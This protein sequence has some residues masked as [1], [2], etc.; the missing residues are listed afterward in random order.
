MAT[1]RTPH[2]L[3]L[4]CLL[5]T[6]CTI[7]IVQREVIVQAPTKITPDSTIEATRAA[8]PERAD[9]S[10]DAYTAADMQI[11]P[12]LQDHSVGG[13]PYI[14]DIAI[15][16]DGVWVGSQYGVS[17]FDGDSWITY[18]HFDGNWVNYASDES[19]PT[20]HVVSSVRAVAVTPDGTVWVGGEM[21]IASFDG[22]RWTTHSDSTLLDTGGCHIAV[23]SIAVGQDGKLWASTYLGLICFDGRTWTSYPVPIYSTPDGP[24]PP[25]VSDIAVAHDGSVWGAAWPDAYHFDG[26]TWTFYVVAGD[27][28]L[29]RT[30]DAIT[31][32]D[33][34]LEGTIDANAVAIADDG[35]VWFGG[36]MGI[37]SFDGTSWTSYDLPSGLHDVADIALAPEGTLWFGGHNG[38]SHSDGYNW[39]TYT[40]AD[41][42]IYHIVRSIAIADDGTVWI[43]TESGLSCYRPLP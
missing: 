10:W 3:L 8:Q 43:G 42:L 32:I 1:K 12:A 38:I 16:P 37:A 28:R 41:G 36:G 17:H 23:R 34:G 7:G 14:Y 26:S 24:S 15:A 19:T 25:I 20:G 21:G 6:A 40:V 9:S 22:T 18:T 4:G 30:V 39:T 35:T 13:S 5:L 2:L 33:D 27:D 29:E 31:I 11:D